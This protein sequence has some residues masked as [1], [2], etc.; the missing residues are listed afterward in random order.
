M[1]HALT[2][3]GATVTGSGTGYRP[4]WET[5][6]RIALVQRYTGLRISQV[7]GMDWADLD[8]DAR[9]L[10]I[11]SGSKGSKGQRRDRMVPL[12]PALVDLFREWEPKTSGRVFSRTAT[13]GP[14]RGQEIEIRGDDAIGPLVGAWKRAGIDEDKWAAVGREKGR[15]THAIRA[16]WKS[17]NTA[18]DGYELA[19]LM[20]GQAAK[21]SDH[22]AY[23][24]AGASS[25]YWSRMVAALEAIP[26]HE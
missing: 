25:P 16:T 22:D 21:H 3:N 20:A 11:R 23:V 19:T 12:H 2:P 14:R 5:Y 26:R 7:C 13:K 24:T 15:P 1:I 4:Q 17:A 6:R 18:A 8:L 10:W 9:S